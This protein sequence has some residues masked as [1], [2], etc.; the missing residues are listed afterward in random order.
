MEAASALVAEGDLEQRLAHVADCLLQVDD[1]HV[2]PAALN[3]FVRVRNTVIAVPR[4]L[5]DGIIPRDV[6]KQNAKAAA[7]GVLDLLVTELGGL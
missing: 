5:R 2:P 4:V 1:R 3:A 6:G 7:L